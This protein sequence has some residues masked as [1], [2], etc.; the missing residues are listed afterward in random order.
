MSSAVTKLTV[1]G[2]AGIALTLVS[3]NGNK[4]AAE[5]LREQAAAAIEASDPAGAIILLDSLDKAYPGEIATRRAAMPLRPKAIELQTLRELEINDSLTASTAVMVDQM[6]D[7]I[8]FKQGA[9]GTDGYYV[10]TAMSNAIP[11]EGEGIYPRMSPEG[12]FYIIS[13]AR[14]GSRSIA[15]A[16]SAPGEGE[17]STPSVAHD[18]E[19]NDRSLPTE[20]ITFLPAESD[21]IGAFVFEN[22]DKNLTLTIKGEGGNRNKALSPAET[23]SIAQLYAASQIY[24]RA[25]YLARQKQ[26]LEQRL[27]L[28][29]SQQ[30]R[31]MPD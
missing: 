21:T 23:A 9:G 14:K 8:T 30:A 13:S 18:G 11:S 31:L 22:A 25:A 28:S 19:R 7:N 16:V 4:D 1:A 6:K 24:R 27:M 15:V 2:L 10:A 26:A 3:C 29:R 20:V 12:S 17:A 5:A